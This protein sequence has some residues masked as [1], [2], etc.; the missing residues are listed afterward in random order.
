MKSENF[1]IVIDERGLPPRAINGL[2]DGLRDRLHR[3]L[4]VTAV[5]SDDGFYTK[6]VMP[7]EH[8][9][10][11]VIGVTSEINY[12]V[13]SENVVEFSFNGKKP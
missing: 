13:T 4:I 3:N 8:D 7:G 5:P 9:F 1:S 6:I 2:L 11:D 12:W 10:K